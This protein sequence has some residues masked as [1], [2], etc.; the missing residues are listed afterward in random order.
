M[1]AP[2]KEKRA[3]EGALAVSGPDIVMYN[4]FGGISP[5]GAFIG[6]NLDVAI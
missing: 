6:R 3:D 4:G 2:E 1:T 5:A